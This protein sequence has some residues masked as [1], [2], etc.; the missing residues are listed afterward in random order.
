MPIQNRYRTNLLKKSSILARVN[1]ECGAE[2]AWARCPN[3]E[4]P[5]QSFCSC[6][7]GFKTKQFVTALSLMSH[8]GGELEH[9][10]CPIF[11]AKDTID[12]KT[13]QEINF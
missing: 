11:E 7:W 6:K 10:K 1:E 9:S 12:L 4:V 13:C 8:S 5:C 2:L 3:L